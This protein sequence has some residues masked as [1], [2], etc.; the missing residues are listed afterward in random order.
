MARPKTQ[1]QDR[2]WS[3][4][5][6]DFRIGFWGKKTKQVQPNFARHVVISDTITLAMTEVPDLILIGSFAN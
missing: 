5:G 3:D 4:I 6:Q 2:Y 1:D